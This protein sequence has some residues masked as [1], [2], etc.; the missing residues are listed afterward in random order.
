MPIGKAIRN[1]KTYIIVPGIDEIKLC[2]EGEDGELCVAGIG[3]GKGYINNLEK[4][5]ST[6]INNPFSDDEDYSILY[7]QE[8]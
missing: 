1:L 7:R 6:F 4:T 5:Q 2:S 3:V 8:I